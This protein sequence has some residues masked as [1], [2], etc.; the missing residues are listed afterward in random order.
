M[1]QSIK[2]SIVLSC[3]SLGMSM[4]YYTAIMSYVNAIFLGTY[5]LKYLAYFYLSSALFYIV[6]SNLAAPYFANHLRLTITIIL[7]LIIIIVGASWWWHG[8][9]SLSLWYP[10]LGCIFFMATGKFLIQI[11]WNIASRLLRIRD[12]KNASNI[13]GAA[14]AMGGILMGLLGPIIIRKYTVIGL[15]PTIEIFLVINLVLVYYISVDQTTLNPLTAATT[16]QRFHRQYNLQTLLIYF[17]L[18]TLIFST[19]VD[20]MFKYQVKASF[21]PERIAIFTSK[22]S[23][24]SYTLTLLVELL[25]IK[26]VVQRFGLRTFIL[27]VPMLMLALSLVVLFKANLITIAILWVA[28]S[29]SN[30]SVLD[31]SFQ[32]L[33]NALPIQLR[34]ISKLRAKAI[35]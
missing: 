20:Y 4:M 18:G 11:Y 31:L 3:I 23:A 19:L 29:V 8:Y 25:Y 13:L 1:R 21:S 2:F 14:T 10:F 6:M 35:G 16:P 26:K 15:M 17:A 33:G 34:T 28:Y 22:L 24:L 27:Q 9:M 32:L 30:L 12:F 5:P 7:S